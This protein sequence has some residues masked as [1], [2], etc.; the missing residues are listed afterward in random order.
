MLII[1]QMQD[2]KT[3]I[4][5]GLFKRETK[6]QSFIG[7]QVTLSTGNEQHMGYSNNRRLGL[8]YVEKTLYYST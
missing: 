2:E 6:I 7:L 8:D 3:L 4:G 5:K 1:F